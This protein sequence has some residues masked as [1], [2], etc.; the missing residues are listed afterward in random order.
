MRPRFQ[1]PGLGKAW[2]ARAIFGLLAAF[3]VAPQAAY[4]Q[5]RP[6]SPVGVRLYAIQNARIVTVS[7]Q[8]IDR[9]TV[10]VQNGI[11][12]AVGSN[13]SVPAG[14]WVI[15]GT[16]KTV[17]PGLFD[18]LTTLGHGSVAPQQGGF[19]GGGGP[20]GAV[21]DSNH[22]WGPEDRPG[23]S[24]WLTAADDLD[25]EDDR[26]H[27]WRSAGFTTV[28]STL[29][30]GLVTGQAAVL[31][32]GSY[33]RP[34]ELVVA[35][36][37]AM[38]VNLLD[39]S[40]TGYPG[41]SMGVFAYLKQLYYDGKNYQDVWAAYDANPRG[42]QRPEWDL[43]LEPVRQQLREGWPVLFPA[44]NRN[45]V[46]QAIKTTRE[47]GVTP[48]VYGA[49]GAYAAADLL[50][51]AGISTLVNLDWPSAPANGD[52]DAVPALAQ[53]RLYDRAPTTPGILAAAGVKFAFY[54]GGLSNASDMVSSA[55]R[56][57]AQGLSEADAIRAFTLSPAEIF[58]VAD[59]LGSIEQGKIANLVVTSGNIFTEGTEIESIFVD[60]EMFDGSETTAAGP[61]ADGPTSA[62][63]RGGRGG[64]GGGRS[65]G[66]DMEAPPIPM[67]A[68]K[69]AFRSDPV[70]FI[71]GATIMTASHGTIENGDIIIRN[72]KIAE[73][74]T[75]LSRPSGAR[76]VD[77]TG[78]FVT[79]GII[80]AHSHLAAGSI[81]EGSVSVSSMVTI[82]DV[83]EP[84]DN[85]IYLA[86]A[87]GVTSMNVLHGS[88]NP[89]GG[90]NAVLKL[91][92]GADADDM[93]IGAHPGIKF[94]LGENTKRDRNPD[95]YPATRMGVQDVIRQAFLD[96]QEY[97]KEHDAYEAGGSQGVAP[98][99][100]LKLES[101][102]Q[103]L[104]GDRWVHSHSY[105]ADE[106]LQLIRLADEFGFT[107]RTFQHVLE[108][109]KVA[110]E[111]AAHGAGA[112]TF[113]DWWAYKVEAY[114]AIP[115]NAALMADRGVLVSINSD[116]GE[117]IRHLNQ[118]AAKTM[119]WGDME[120][121][122]ALRL[123][124]L[125]P[126]IQL[127]IDDQTGSIDEGKDADLVIWEGH[128]LS[129]FGKAVQT[130]VDGML[131]FDLEMDLERQAAIADEKGA[132][133]EK[134]GSGEAGGRSSTDRVASPRLSGEDINR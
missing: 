127:G 1:I 131:Y 15:D 130:Y 78:K 90:G 35:T 68:D 69:G 104:K 67:S 100:D 24:S 60:G 97:M 118:E 86:L 8:T 105:R 43:A 91:R 99:R 13:V 42:K 82:E 74:G 124:T 71:T 58:G 109:Y 38:R 111:I 89:I 120:E 84:E 25:A 106:I 55:R 64:R 66:P 122:P 95:R 125:N 29:P 108:G 56:A 61:D 5:P 53:L 62:A 10:I 114:D 3:V 57:I 70:T 37:V 101:L 96:A 26:L 11:I 115:Y 22:S 126:A 88:A 49:Q 121:E 34:R 17:Y 20:G 76:V 72:G 30:T 45:E 134:H 63:G 2:G 93:L 73:V 4:G 32:L 12:A 94:A 110:D 113:S 40:F 79:P 112:S 119:K 51:S 59:R 83:I 103:I 128:P 44:T 47:M 28:L 27:S 48:I 14:A 107:I 133:M 39:R 116:S 75:G 41:S 54:S 23:T 7:G 87:G 117:E 33:A 16:G 19:F 98:R 50:A 6:T 21:D 123:V 81:N 77:A 52:P 9:G 92:W 129:M 80:D 36:P 85:G 18:A 132:L 46:G 65:A 102:M 31:N